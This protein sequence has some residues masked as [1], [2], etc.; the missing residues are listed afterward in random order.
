MRGRDVVAANRG[1]TFKGDTPEFIVR[2]HEVDPLP[3][4][5]PFREIATIDRDR[6][7]PLGS[8]GKCPDSDLPIPGTVGLIQEEV[9]IRV[10]PR[11]RLV[12]CVNDGN[13]RMV[14]LG[15]R[16]GFAAEPCAIVVAC[17]RG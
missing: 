11:H 3:G 15:G 9:A 10:D 17:Q 5:I 1:D 8:I 13:M 14:E 4:G 7:V 12:H 6:P 16:F 2:R